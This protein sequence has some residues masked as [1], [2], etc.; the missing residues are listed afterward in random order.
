MSL[1]ADALDEILAL[2]PRASVIEEGGLAYI[3]LPVLI[4]P[5]GDAAEALLCLSGR[6]G[7]PTRLFLSRPVSG[8]GNNWSVHRILDKAWH[9]WSWKDVPACLRPIDILMSHLDALR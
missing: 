6:D 9:T 4:L 3:H 5:D 8:K 1:T 7:Y 2:C